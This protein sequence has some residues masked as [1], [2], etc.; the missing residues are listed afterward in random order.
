MFI[1][2]SHFVSD[3]YNF[4]PISAY[5]CHIKH[6]YYNAN[7]NVYN[8]HFGHGVGSPSFKN[9]STNVDLS[10]RIKIDCISS[11]KNI[12]YLSTVVPTRKPSE[13]INGVRWGITVLSEE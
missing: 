13:R 11:L 7:I 10:V 1:R 9:Q 4:S 3:Y 12:S 8:F 5:E 6:F 2:T